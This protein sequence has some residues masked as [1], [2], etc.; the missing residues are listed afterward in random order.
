MDFTHF[1]PLVT[2][3]FQ[4]PQCAGSCKWC[5][6][7]IYMAIKSAVPAVQL[8]KKVTSYNEGGDWGEKKD[9][10][11]TK[12]QCPGCHGHSPLRMEKVSNDSR[13][14][15]NGGLSTFTPSL[16]KQPLLFSSCASLCK[17]D[18]HLFRWWWIFH[19]LAN[20]L[21]LDSDV[22]TFE[23]SFSNSDFSEGNCGT[24]IGKSH[25]RQKLESK[26]SHLIKF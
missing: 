26:S 3:V 8:S 16:E 9:R 25:H 12:T 4:T 15:Q 2:S 11:V 18:F 21:N 14:C 19:E 6:C 5:N 20:G 1:P 22:S 23:T 24:Q 17:W 13:K 7:D 10:E